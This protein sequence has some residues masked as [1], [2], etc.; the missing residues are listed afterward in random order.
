MRSIVQCKDCHEMRPLKGHGLCSRCYGRASAAGAFEA[1][2]RLRRAG[3]NVRFRF[4]IDPKTGCWNW[5]GSKARHGYGQTFKGKKVAAHRAMYEMVHGNIPPGLEIDH[6][7]RNKGC[8]N[9]AHLEAVTH[10]ENVRRAMPHF[11]PWRKTHCKR[12]HAL[13]E[14]NL[15]IRPD[16][17]QR[18]CLACIRLRTRKAVAS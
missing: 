7:C 13:V 8:V 1:R 4:R 3:L 15:Y 17:G 5:T 18:Q 16:N 10:T 2:A 6:L 9:P 14:G 12:G 11:T